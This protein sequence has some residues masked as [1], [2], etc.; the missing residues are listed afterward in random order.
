VRS[1]VPADVVRDAEHMAALAE[2]QRARRRLRDREPELAAIDL[3]R[4]DALLGVP[5]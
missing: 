1:Y 2:A 5:L 3:T 4:Y